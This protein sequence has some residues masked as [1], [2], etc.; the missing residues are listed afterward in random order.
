MGITEINKTSVNNLI[1]HVEG[2]IRTVIE[3]GHQSITIE[4]LR[5]LVKGRTNDKVL[6]AMVDDI[7][8]V[9][10]T[11]GIPQDFFEEQLMSYSS[12]VGTG[13]PIDKVI[14]AIKFTTLALAG[15]NNTK[16]YELVFPAK[17]AQIHARG[18][19]CDSFACMYAQS[20]AVVTIMK[21]A[22]LSPHI[23]YRPLEA[24]VMQKLTELMDGKGA[25]ETDRV[26]STVQLNAALGILGYIK[27]PEDKTI[28]LN[29]GMSDG[30][31]AVQE[32][33]AEQIRRIADM[34][35]A[36]YRRG[37]SLRDIQRVGIVVDT[38]VEED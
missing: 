18:Q 15:T 17:A 38:I 37:G 6:Q 35:E 11:Y 34:Q 29:L 22:L 5:P 27:P 16:A 26:S 20:K 31:A 10:E 21:T 4:T 14:N 28:A 33:L 36:E 1:R 9:E 23:V 19:E 8:A 3:E 7:H 12:M 24:R 32:N 2:E 30:A 25:R 13:M